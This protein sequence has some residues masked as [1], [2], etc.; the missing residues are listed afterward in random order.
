MAEAYF[1]GEAD[2][3][4]TTVGT[5]TAAVLWNNTSFVDTSFWGVGTPTYN[6]FL[7]HTSFVKGTLRDPVTKAA[8]PQSDLWVHFA[9][10]SNVYGPGTSAGNLVVLVTGG[11]ETTAGTP[12]MRLR[13]NKA[14]TTGT[15]G[16]L[17]W[18]WWDGSA[19]QDVGTF[20]PATSTVYRCAVR[21]KLHASAGL[22]EFFVEGAQVGASVTG[23]TTGGASTIAAIELQG[24]AES[25]SATATGILSYSQVAAASADVN[26]RYARVAQDRPDAAPGGSH[27]V[28]MTGDFSAIDEQPTSDADMISTTTTG[29]AESWRVQQRAA[30][31]TGMTV[32][33]FGQSVRAR[34]GATGP[35]NL[36]LTVYVGGTEYT[37]G[38]LAGVTTAF[39]THE[40]QWSADPAAPATPITPAAF[41]AY[42]WGV[43]ATA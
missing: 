37:S 32:V 8:T 16:D 26:M 23:D 10:G 43:K 40:F 36:Q 2:I 20:T 12:V 27:P 15:A 31:A 13:R 9:I 1:V 34:I 39:A 6:A 29:A 33:L 7:A 3:K 24:M 41:D 30:A 5:L 42:R 17:T 19:W 14:L 25:P 4:Y 22:I 28:A 18:Q 11:T 21:V 38:D 35:Q